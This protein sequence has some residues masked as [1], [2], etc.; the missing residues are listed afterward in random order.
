M[1]RPLVLAAVL[2]LPGPAAVPAETPRNAGTPHG[3]EAPRDSAVLRN[4]D[5]FL[6][7]VPPY[8]FEFPRDH[9]AHPQY[10][11]EWWYYTGHLRSG[12]RELG[13]ET[14]FFRFGLPLMSEPDAPAGAARD[15]VFLNVA[16]TDEQGRRFLYHDAAHRAAP[17]VAGTDSTRYHVWLDDSEAGLKDDGRTHRLRAHAPDFELDLT[18]TPLKPPVMHGKD[19][20]SQKGPGLGNASHYYSFTRLA[21]AGHIGPLAVTGEAWMDH[22]FSSN[23]L[24]G[25]YSGWDWFS[26]QLDDSTDWMLYMLRRLDGTIEP[27]SAGTRVA[28]DGSTRSLARAAFRVDTTGSWTS[29]HTGGRYPMGW[30]ISVPGEALDLVL[31][32][33]LEDQELVTR[34]MGGVVYWEGA[35]RVRGTRRGAKVT[36]RGYVEL[37]GY[38][39]RAPY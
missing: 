11:V 13:F 15:L 22:E 14:T 34:T 25:A 30:R 18:L 38:T 12:V 27:L 4:A 33:V 3:T 31:E 5:G 2:A 28:P 1:C 36:G 7:A 24:I 29:P 23:R 6:L 17:G 21:A 9:A 37:T 20:V 16:L 32:P 19:G 10:Q 39:G 8:R 26:V 35:V